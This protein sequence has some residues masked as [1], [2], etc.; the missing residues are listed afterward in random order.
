MSPNG[1]DLASADAS[2]VDSR[3]WTGPEAASGAIERA[4][5]V[6]GTLPRPVY[7]RAEALA[8]N[9]RTAPHHHPWGQ[10]SYAT[11]GVLAIHTPAGRF[12]APPQRAVW[13]PP[14]VPHVVTTSARAEQ[15][16]LYVDGDVAATMP[17]A[18]RVL[19]VSALARELIVA[20]SVLPRHYD[21][22]GAEGRLVTVLLDTLAALPPADLDLP[23]PSDPRVARLCAALQAAPEDPRTLGDWGDTVGLSARSL[24]R[25]FRAET[26]MTFGDW[27]LR[28]RMLLALTPLEAGTS[29]TAVALDSGYDSP[30]AFIAAF[31]R[32]FG[33]TPRGLFERESLPLP[34]VARR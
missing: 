17:A 15:R 29:V 32:V 24:A 30:S 19:M 12:V 7:A 16:S 33:H 34:R 23:L 2:P 11:T 3:G 4:V 21:S 18:C 9:S 13:I 20:V 27:R 26:G 22:D 31:R 6:I 5:P 28:L 10:L 1:Q 8:A 14:G 25:L